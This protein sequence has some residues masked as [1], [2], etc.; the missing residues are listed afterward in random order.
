WIFHTGYPAFGCS[1]RSCSPWYC[2]S[3]IGGHQTA[4]FNWE[5]IGLSCNTGPGSSGGPYLEYWNGGWYQTAVQS[6]CAWNGTSC[7]GTIWGPRFN[8]QTQDLINWASTH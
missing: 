4:Y 5:I 8:T 1:G 7:T 6:V 2:L 3:P